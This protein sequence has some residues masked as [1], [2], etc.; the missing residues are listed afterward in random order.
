MADLNPDPPPD[1]PL[2]GFECM[3]ATNTYWCDR[4]YDGSKQ[5]AKTCIYPGFLVYAAPQSLVVRDQVLTKCNATN[6]PGTAITSLAVCMAAWE[7]YPVTVVSG[8]S[9]YANGDPMEGIALEEYIPS[10]CS[11][12]KVDGVYTGVV[13]FNEAPDGQGDSSYDLLCMDPVKGQ[14]C[15]EK[16]CACDNGVG[17]VGVDC[18][19]HGDQA[20]AAADGGR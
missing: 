9:T 7:G 17:A 12:K 6:S 4:D 5:A 20:C 1:P 18:P 15:C 8:E 19:Y 13:V 14:F 10:G 16:K 3:P 11:M 2:E